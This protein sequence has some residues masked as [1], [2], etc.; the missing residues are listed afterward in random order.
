MEDDL[1]ESKK[2]RHTTNRRPDG[3]SEITFKPLQ[4]GRYVI[5]IEFNNK[6]LT[7]I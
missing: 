4:V 3:T 5:N 6:P 2:L 1:I 7:G